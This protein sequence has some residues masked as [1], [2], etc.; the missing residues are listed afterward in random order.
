VPEHTGALIGRRLE[1]N[2][3]RAALDGLEVATQGLFQI[4][5]EQG[6]GKTRLI[7]ELC[8]EAERRR[9]LVFSGR[10]AEFEQDEAF[11]VFVD[12]LDE[13]LASLDGLDLDDLVVEM[14]ELASVFPALARVAEHPL[15][16]MPAE[17][18]RAH[19]A[20]RALLDRLSRQRPVVLTLD[21]LHWA[22][23]ASVEL[24]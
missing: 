6:I 17:R 13:F 21:D 24:V 1:W 12:A 16:T 14:A 8:A 5:G 3:L 4:A 9:Y 18:Y 23:G 2:L 11:G 10:A 22:D 15:E 19:Q 7:A 20:V